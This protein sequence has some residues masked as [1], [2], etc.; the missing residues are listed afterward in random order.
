MLASKSN[1]DISWPTPIPGEALVEEIQRRAHYHVV[2]LQLCVDGHW[3]CVQTRTDLLTC[4]VTRHVWAHRQ[5]LLPEG[6]RLVLLRRAGVDE[7]QSAALY[8]PVDFVAP[9]P[10]FY[11]FLRPRSELPA[12]L[13]RSLA[14]VVVETSWLRLQLMVERQR[15]SWMIPLPWVAQAVGVSWAQAHSKPQPMKKPM[16]SA[17]QNWIASE[18]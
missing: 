9:S 12:P 14:A 6:A 13:H 8:E 11:A 3:Q 4:L 17:L 1:V 7:A 15:A 5:F 18:R 10:T 2:G 16:T